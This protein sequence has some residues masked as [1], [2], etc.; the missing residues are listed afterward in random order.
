MISE[1]GFESN[2]N[3]SG[4]RIDRSLMVY[5]IEA[6]WNNHSE[7]WQGDCE[8]SIEE[9]QWNQKLDQIFKRKN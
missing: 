5:L 2:Q 1:I 8:V 4:I 9:R 3:Q 6:H 7:T